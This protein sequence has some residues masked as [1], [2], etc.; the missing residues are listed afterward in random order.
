[1][2]AHG[3]GSVLMRFMDRMG[4]DY[5]KIGGVGGSFPVIPGLKWE[6]DQD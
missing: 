6:M 3:A 5:K 1:M 4:W 2:A